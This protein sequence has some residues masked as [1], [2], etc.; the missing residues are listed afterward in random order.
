MEKLLEKEEFELA[1]YMRMRREL[2]DII[3][4]I[5]DEEMRFKLRDSWYSFGRALDKK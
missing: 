4:R 5:M 3:E 2:N 1:E